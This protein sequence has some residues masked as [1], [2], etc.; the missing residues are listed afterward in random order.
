MA[1]QTPPA[2]GTDPRLGWPDAGVADPFRRL[3]AKAYR[4]AADSAAIAR[5]T[6]VVQAGREFAHSVNN[7]LSLPLGVLELLEAQAGV[8]A[9]MQSLVAAARE[10]LACAATQADDFHARARQVS[11]I[12]GTPPN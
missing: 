7:L 10:A 9:D 1:L 3:D 2:S 6:S 4:A 12:V 11:C 8:P 5:L